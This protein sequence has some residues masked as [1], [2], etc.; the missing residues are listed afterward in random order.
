MVFIM[1]Q[2]TTMETISKLE[3]KNTLPTAFTPESARRRVTAINR[4]AITRGLKLINAHF[5]P[6]PLQLLA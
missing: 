6:T 2:D 4:S 3:Y 1:P 5:L